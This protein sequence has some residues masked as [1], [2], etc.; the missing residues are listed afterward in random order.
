MNDT[1]AFP[2]ERTLPCGSLQECEGMMLR[3]YFA[4][5]IL[6]TYMMNEV[7]NPETYQMAARTSYRLADQMM[8]A[9]EE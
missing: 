4:A 3:D 6:Q 9:R 8:K 7:W 1:P 2:Q 5:R